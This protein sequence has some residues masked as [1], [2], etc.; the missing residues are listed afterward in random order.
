MSAPH[1][2]LAYDVDEGVATIT[3]RR[4]ERLN[5]FN[6]QMM[7]DL[8]DAFDRAD[9]DDAVRAV[10]VTGDGRAFCA[11]ADI[12]AGADI[13]DFDGA[14][15]GAPGDQKVAGVQ[16]DGGGRVAL[17][18]FAC[19]KPVIAAV[20]GPAVG[21][22]VTMQLPM[23]VR[24]ASSDAR[25][26]FVFTRRGLTPEAC[27]SWFLPRLVGPSRALEWICAGRM[28]SAQ[29]ALEA[30]LVRAIHAPADLM[31]AARSLA[32]EIA[33]NAAP[34]AVALSRRLVWSMMTADHPM[35]AHALE[36][37]AL[38]ALGATEDCREGVAAFKA[39]RSP[40]FS[41]RVSRDLPNFHPWEGERRF[42]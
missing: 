7:L 42:L 10:I 41:G 5:A 28:V 27:S 15:A 21:V 13:F 12:A 2:T 31:P 36:S 33:E 4:P 23:D 39:R 16:R 29:E 26:G 34:V 18:I 11:G 14:G 25:F 37:R 22:G 19:L 38:H 35:T 30:G 32:R 8:I 17:R 6:S 1:E 20:N 40:A 9:A 24:L 3:L